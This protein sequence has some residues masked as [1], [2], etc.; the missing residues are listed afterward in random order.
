M[1]S[2][3]L[4]LGPGRGGVPREEGLQRRGLRGSGVREPEE[5]GARGKAALGAEL[6]GGEDGL[7]DTSCG[8]TCRGGG[9]R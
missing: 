3:S 9:R 2:A 4:A 7:K 1:K 8:Q 5:G 6:Q